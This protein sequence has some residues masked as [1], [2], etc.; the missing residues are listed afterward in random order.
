MLFYSILD[1]IVIILDHG[2][3]EI[4]VDHL[5][6]IFLDHIDDLLTKFIVVLDI[7]DRTVDFFMC[8]FNDDWEILLFGLIRV[9]IL[10]D[11]FFPVLIVD[12]LFIFYFCD[13]MIIL[14]FIFLFDMLASFVMI[15]CVEIYQ[16]SFLLFEHNVIF[17]FFFFFFFSRFFFLYS[18]MVILQS[19]SF[20]SSWFV[21][22]LIL[23]INN[24]NNICFK[25]S[26]FSL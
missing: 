17:F 23:F 25:N 2:L 13:I 7:F 19:D 11:S 16:C 4:L 20:S 15:H 10:G 6:F 1:Q 3:S 5:Y 14:I 8:S 9:Q 21:H 26:L 18:M 22:P 12:A 24:I